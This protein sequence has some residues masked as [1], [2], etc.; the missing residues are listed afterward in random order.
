MKAGQLDR[1]IIIQSFTES[2]DASGQ[3]IQSW[4]T[5][6]TVFANRKMVKGNERFTSEQ[7]MAV[8]TATFR[9]RWLAGITEEMRI[10]DAGSMYRI[11][12]IASDQREGWIEISAAATNPEATQ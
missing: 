4:A 11:L 7:R 8:R 6:A 12:G 10:T 9:F 1:E 5:F 2:Q 3:P